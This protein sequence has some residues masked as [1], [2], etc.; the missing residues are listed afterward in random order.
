MRHPT[1]AHLESGL[2]EVRRSPRDQGA[3][4]MIVRR[5]QTGNREL[6]EEAELSLESGLVGDN[7]SSR[8]AGPAPAHPDRQIAIMNARAT[9]LVAS[10]RDRWQLAGDQ[11]YI[12]LDLS[13]GN[14]PPGSRLSIGSA[15]VEVTGEPQ[16]GCKKFIERFGKDAMRFVNSPVGKGLNLRGVYARILEPGVIRVGNMVSRA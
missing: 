11:L 14:L 12:D 5:P 9:M 10:T 6:L 4:E 7:W 8:V 16:L 15:I 1:I 2:D 13:P 3:L